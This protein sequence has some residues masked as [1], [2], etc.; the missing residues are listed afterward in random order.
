MVEILCTISCL[1]IKFILRSSTVFRLAEEQAGLHTLSRP[2]VRSAV[3]RQ[4]QNY[5][6]N[7][8]VLKRLER[9]MPA[10]HPLEA[11]DEDC[12]LCF[13][14]STSPLAARRAWREAKYMICPHRA[15]SSIVGTR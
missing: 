9:V 5:R 15:F 2:H 1:Q 14:Q 11:W 10:R 4:Q 6:S 13:P 7:L 8:Q 3:E 12:C